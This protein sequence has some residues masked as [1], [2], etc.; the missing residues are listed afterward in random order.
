MK[1]IPYVLL[2]DDK[3]TDDIVLGKNILHFKQGH[4]SQKKP[5]FET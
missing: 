5:F 1:P 4:L 3:V 2:P